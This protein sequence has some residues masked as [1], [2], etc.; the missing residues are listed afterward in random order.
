VE[1]PRSFLDQ[2]RWWTGG[3][4]WLAGLPDR[5]HEQCRRWGLEAGLTEDPERCRRLATAFA[6]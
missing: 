3:A 5:I 2:P 1:I 6:G 4:D